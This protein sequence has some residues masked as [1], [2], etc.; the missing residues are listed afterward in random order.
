MITPAKNDVILRGRNNYSAFQGTELQSILQWE[1]IQKL[2][3]AGFLTNVCILETVREAH[4]L[5]LIDEGL[6]IFV[7]KDCCAA[8]SV[9]EHDYAVNYSLP[10]L[11]KTIT[12]RQVLKSISM[13]IEETVGKEA[14]KAVPKKENSIRPSLHHSHHLV[15]FAWN[16]TDFRWRSYLRYGLFIVLLQIILGQDYIFTD[17]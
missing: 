3:I 17:G 10:S 16:R 13:N 2:Y 8:E 4:D 7:V 15:S 5:G 12:S 11:C 9:E 6:Q 14:D 1:R